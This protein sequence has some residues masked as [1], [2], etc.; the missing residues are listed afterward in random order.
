MTRRF[1]V[2]ADKTLIPCI[3]RI[4]AKHRRFVLVLNSYDPVTRRALHFDYPVDMLKTDIERT[5]C[6]IFNQADDLRQ[7]G[8]AC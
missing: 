4:A 7:S 1:S 8:I 6:R 2:K 5:I 3:R